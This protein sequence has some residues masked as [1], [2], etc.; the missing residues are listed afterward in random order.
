MAWVA[1]GKLAG[2]VSEA[3]G[4]GIIA[5]M[6]SNGQQLTEQIRILRSITH[7]TFAVNIMLMSPFVEEVVDTVI[8]EKVPVVTTGAG[9]P[10]KYMAR[11]QAA[12]IK[13]IPVVASVAH[14]KLLERHGAVALVAEGLEAGG[15]IGPSTTMTLVPMLRDAVNIPIIAAGGI[16]DGRGFLAALALGADGIQ[17]GTRFLVAKESGIHEN[18]KKKVL[19]A[20]DRETIVTGQVTGHPVRSAKSPLCRR[21]AELEKDPNLDLKELEALGAGSLRKAV[22]EGDEENGSFMM[23]ISAGLV[24]KEETAQEILDDMMK[25]LALEMDRVASWAK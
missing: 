7:K 15:H 6:N 10:M 21:F 12:G 23:G 14:G 25:G 8:R 3:G 1:D 9:N 13:V 18:Y 17:M 2:A 19:K 16:A 20:G 24:F 5:G 4:L 11:L 22:L